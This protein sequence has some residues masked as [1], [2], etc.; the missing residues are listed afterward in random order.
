MRCEEAMELLSAK[1]DGELDP[2]TDAALS[3]HLQTCAACRQVW[4]FY[5]EM[6]AGIAALEAE[7][8]AE[9]YTGVM[10]KIRNTPVVKPVKK[11]RP[12]WGVG[13]AVAAAAVLFLLIGT[14]TVHL[15][16]WNAAGNT[17]GIAMDEAAVVAE[18]PEMEEVEEA[19]PAEAAVAPEVAAETATVGDGQILPWTIERSESSLE[20]TTAEEFQ[21]ETWLEAQELPVLVLEAELEQAEALLQDW[22]ALDWLEIPVELAQWQLLDDNIWC[23]EI[24][25]GLAEQ[26][27]D[28]YDGT[29][30]EV[31]NES[32]TALIVLICEEKE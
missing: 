18:V 10:E 12:M 30:Y 6:D 28:L 17:A 26:I 19:A 13:T 1:L 11:R 27:P 2:Q 32:E 3:R 31:D 25:A 7:P 8:P 22:D 29:W 20:M 23:C 4:A 14:G 21:L 24:D 15:P 5:C 9:L 16:D